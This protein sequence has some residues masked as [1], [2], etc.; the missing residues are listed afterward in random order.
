MSVK[1][2]VILLVIVSGLLAGCGASPV[3][4][5]QAQLSPASGELAPVQ[6]AA[7][8]KLKVVATTNIVGDL[9]KNVGGD[10]ID[11]TVMLPIG[12]DP[13]GFQPAPQDVAAVSNADVIFINGL[14]LERF[15]TSL[16]ENA[17]TQVTVVSLAEGIEPLA[18]TEQDDHDGED[19]E[20]AGEGESADTHGH[21]GTDPHIWLS[22]VNAG[23]MVDNAARALAQLDPAHAPAYQ[24]NAAAYQQRLTE[25][26]GWIQQQVGQIPPAQRKLV[27]DHDTFGYFAGR[28]GFELVGTVIPSFSTNAEPSAQELAGLQQAVEKNGVKA[29]FVGTTVNPVLSSRL[30]DD[31]GIKLVRLYTGSLGDAASGAGTYLDYMRYNTSAIVEALK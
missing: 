29:V 24:A 16:I 23:V 6:L 25:L 3:E 21:G 8:A 7:G 14:G 5:N 13:H 12:A 17:N 30:A 15:L 26:D 9:L 2:A 18:M 20:H 28:Y 4:H 10:G 19:E 22:P 11:L 1:R 31:T 27:T